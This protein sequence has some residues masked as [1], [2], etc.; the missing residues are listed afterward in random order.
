VKNNP[1]L[2]DLDGLN[3]L[4]EVGSLSILENAG[5]VGLAGLEGLT[6]V[7]LLDIRANPQLKDLR[8]LASL[9]QVNQAVLITDNLKLPTCEAD[10]LRARVPDLGFAQIFASGNDDAGVCAP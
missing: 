4:T 3:G 8:K 5:L 6:Q 9:N 1:S 7:G 2:R 10:W